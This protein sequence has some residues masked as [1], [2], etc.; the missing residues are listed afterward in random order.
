MQTKKYKFTNGFELLFYLCD[1]DPANLRKNRDE[2]IRFQIKSDGYFGN[3]ATMIDLL[4]Q[5]S[6]ISDEDRHEMLARIRDD[7]IF[8]QDNFRIIER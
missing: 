7:L 6:V 8:L 2:R 5:S 4:R 3:L 1:G